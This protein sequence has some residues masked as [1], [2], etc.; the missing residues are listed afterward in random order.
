MGKDVISQFHNMFPFTKKGLTLMENHLLEIK[1]CMS[2]I[3]AKSEIMKSNCSLNVDQFPVKYL[4]CIQFDSKDCPWIKDLG[5]TNN[6]GKRLGGNEIVQRNLAA[7]KQHQVQGHMAGE[8]DS[9]DGMAS[10]YDTGTDQ[11]RRPSKRVRRE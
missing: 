1:A 2:A 3:V 9:E 8:D 7:T 10:G 11:H 5:S 6:S 4:T